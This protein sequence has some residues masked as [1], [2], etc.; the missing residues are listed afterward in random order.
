MAITPCYSL[1]TVF[2]TTALK[3]RPQW[4]KTHARC[5]K[6]E[7]IDNAQIFICDAAE[8]VVEEEFYDLV[9][10]PVL[11]SGAISGINQT[12]SAYTATR[13]STAIRGLFRRFLVFIAL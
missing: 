1:R 13:I 12:I 8:A 7:R 4:L 11:Y 2:C 9:F 6:Q 5:G 3:Y 10:L